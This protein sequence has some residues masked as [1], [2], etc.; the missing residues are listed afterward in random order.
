M[1]AIGDNLITVARSKRYTAKQFRA[2]FLWVVGDTPAPPEG[3]EAAA[4]LIAADQHELEARMDKRKAAKAERQARWKA[5]RDAKDAADAH[6]PAMPT[7]PAI[8]A[9]P[10]CNNASV[11]PSARANPPKLDDVLAWARDAVHKPDG[12][13]IPERFVREWYALMEAAEPPWTNT[14]GRSIARNW[15]QEAIYAYRR[16]QQFS[17]SARRRGGDDNQPDDGE[18]SPEYRAALEMG[19][20]AG[21]H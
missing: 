21:R 15:K 13:A 11:I 18:E 17:A 3:C 9:K 16:E 2:L 1:K 6:L 14:R 8:P 7:I 4:E 5:H 20:R 19:A 10:S 12:K